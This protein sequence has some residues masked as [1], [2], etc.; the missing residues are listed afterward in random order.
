MLLTVFQINLVKFINILKMIIARSMVADHLIDAEN[1]QNILNKMCQKI[2][3]CRK[4]LL[5][6]KIKISKN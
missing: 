2:S 6:N 5:H 3:W 1:F 4:I